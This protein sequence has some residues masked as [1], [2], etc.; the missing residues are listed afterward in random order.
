MKKARNPP[1]LNPF[2]VP[3]WDYGHR[4]R[5]FR[6]IT[7]IHNL[8]E[9]LRDQITACYRQQYIKLAEQDRKRN[10]QENEDAVKF[11]DDIKPLIMK[12]QDEYLR[13]AMSRMEALQEEYAKTTNLEK[14][15]EQLQNNRIVLNMRVIYLEDSLSHR[16]ILQNFQYLLKEHYWREKNDWIHRLPQGELEDYKQSI[17]KRSTLNIRVRDEDDAYFVKSF[18]ENQYENVH[19][20][21]LIAFENTTQFLDVLQYLKA[22]SFRALLELHFAMGLHTD[23]SKRYENFKQWSQNDLKRKRET[24]KMRCNRK[25]FTEERTTNLKGKTFGMLESDVVLSIKGRVEKKTDSVLD[26]VLWH[27][28]PKNERKG[29]IKSLSSIEKVG[30]VEL[31][32]LNLLEKLD[33]YPREIIH[34]IENKT[35][36][37]HNRRLRKAQDACDTEQR[38]YQVMKGIQKNLEP[39]FQPPPRK[40]PIPMS[41]LRKRPPPTPPKPPA[42]TH[43]Q[44]LFIEAFTDKDI[45]DIDISSNDSRKILKDIQRACMPFYFDHFLALHGYFP[46]KDFTTKIERREGKEEDKLHY[47]DVLPA[48]KERLRKWKQHQNSVKKYNIS[49]TVDLYRDPESELDVNKN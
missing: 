45:T 48:V 47:K 17:E 33:Q 29:A 44:R 34:E 39:P 46:D 32:I 9:A 13:S 30:K 12:W 49:Q 5:N 41:R 18:F 7:D 2:S 26:T 42:P 38:I 27:L 10:I 3:R 19:H 20:P 28:L 36:T 43:Q 1:K 21:I 6:R 40:R 15:A 8:R 14:E 16:T 24:A 25:Y 23:A 31:I 11:H 37:N 22:R 35:R 4:T